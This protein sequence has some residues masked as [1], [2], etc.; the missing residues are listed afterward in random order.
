MQEAALG[1]YICTFTEML[2]HDKK[3]ILFQIIEEIELI[4]ILRLKPRSAQIPYNS[5]NGAQQMYLLRHN[6]T[7][8]YTDLITQGPTLSSSNTRSPQ[9]PLIQGVRLVSYRFVT[10]IAEHD[11]TKT[12]FSQ[13]H[14]NGF[15]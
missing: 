7:R 10:Q 1:F 12:P 6:R 9:C 14:L 15:F 11:A 4:I 3:F 8:F 13:K 5:R 2:G